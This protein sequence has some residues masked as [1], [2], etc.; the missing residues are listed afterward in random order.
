[1]DR[2][3]FAGLTLLSPEDPLSTDEY[4]FQSLNPAIID[5]LLRLAVQA[6]RHDAHAAMVDPV[7]DPVLTLL[8]AGGT[9][10]ADTTIYV[11]YTLVD[12]DGGETV[13]NSSPDLVT[14]EA[15]I[16]AP[17][18]APALDS[19]TDAGTLVTGTYEYAVTVT[20]GTGGE[21]GIGPSA[22]IVIDPGSDTNEIVL[23]GLTDIL[24]A[25]GGVAWRLWRRV[26]G[27]QWNLIN[28]DGATDTITDD[29]SL[30]PN[31]NVSPPQTTTGTTNGT[32]RLQVTV[33]AGQP[34]EAVSFNIYASVDGNFGNPSLL[35]NYPVADLGSVKE[36]AALNFL[37]GAP[38]TVSRAFP[39]ANRINALTDIINLKWRDAVAALVDL[40]AGGNVTG[41]I[42]LVLADMTLHGWNGDAWV[43]VGGGGGGGGGAPTYDWDTHVI[44]E[45]VPGDK[46]VE[47]FPSDDVIFIDNFGADDSAAYSFSNTLAGSAEGAG[48]IA[49]AGG[50]LRTAGSNVYF[51][52]FGPTGLQGDFELVVKYV[53]NADTDRFAVVVSPEALSGVSYVEL[54]LEPGS[55]TIGV[56]TFNA[57]SPEINE[58]DDWFFP[59][60][61]GDTA[62]VR[63]TR[64]GAD[65]TIEDWRTDPA[66]GGAP[67]HSKAVTVSATVNTDTATDQ[68]WIRLGATTIGAVPYD[69]LRAVMPG[70]RKL[71]LKIKKADG[72][73]IT[74]VVMDEDGASELV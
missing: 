54:S 44:W 6:H 65:F 50:V 63:V 49:I 56:R 30:C 12:A 17:D 2:T 53:Q 11:G 32:S 19:D 69:N 28:A 15:G 26:N 67:A 7:L 3:P 5:Q 51:K 31:C 46:T 60:D 72:S 9:I 23:T 8:D 43:S 62:W 14:T 18:S 59:P 58:S 41:D 57:G 29:G 39:G 34:A 45:K 71:N 25:T 38:P 4:S 20:D 40:P 27:G 1:M 21:S 66:L 33:P 35:G 10:P 68:V 70:P 24:T 52:F 37:D 61:P 13:L 73:S 42:R 16:E 47:L 22:S 64:V 55:P 36:Y 48:A 74:K